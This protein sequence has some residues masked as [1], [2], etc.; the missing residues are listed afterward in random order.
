LS[1]EIVGVVQDAP[2]GLLREPH[3][4]VVYRPMLQE[5]QLA[6]VPNA[7][8]RVRGDL[9]AASDA[10]ARIVPTLGR[11]VVRSVDTL[12]EQVSRSLLQERLVA[13]LASA[14]AGLAVLLAAIGV[15]G[16]LSQAVAR[17]T[18]EVGVR[19]ALGATRGSVLR[20]VATDAIRL[21]G[22]GVVLGVPCAMSVAPLGRSLLYGVAPSDSA[23]LVSAG[24]VFILIALAAGLVPAFRASRVEAAVALRHE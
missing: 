2:V 8:V 9:R 5:P 17:R 15:Y 23:S 22:F 10:Y 19:M 6:R 13:G 1:V 12:D 14:S 7:S 21:A 20:M 18:R 4:A 11:H 16:L 3:V 24:A